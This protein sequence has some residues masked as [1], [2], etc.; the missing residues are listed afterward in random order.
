MNTFDHTVHATSGRAA[1]VTR[2]TPWGTGIS[3]PAGTAEKRQLCLDLGAEAAIDYREEDFVE[4]VRAHTK[5]RGGVGGADVVLDNMGA[6]YLQRNV[7]VLADEGRLVIIGMQGGVKGELD[8]SALLRKR[9][10]VVATTLRSRPAADK[11]AICASVVDNVWPL[12]ADGSVR[13]VVHTT[14]PLERVAD[15]HRMLEDSAHVGKVVLT[16]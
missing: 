4:V 14:L 7:S 8:I 15:A 10:A 2:S 6:K 16:L 13:P 3:C 5:D 11:A 9:G 1:A 12:V